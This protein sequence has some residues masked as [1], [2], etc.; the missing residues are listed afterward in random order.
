MLMLSSKLFDLP[1]LSLRAGNRISTA[2]K[3]II[4]PNNLKILGWW[5]L[6]RRE[7]HRTVLLTE[8]VREYSSRGL[9]VDDLDVLCDPSDLTRHKEILDIDFELLNKPVKTKHRK[10]GKVNDYNYNEGMFVQKLYVSRPVINLLSNDSTLIIDRSQILEVTDTHILV[11]DT[12]IEDKAT[13]LSAEAI[14]G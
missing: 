2:V 7:K 10:I 3:P 8:D 5:C 4:D 12:E 1:I 6:D 13:A 11:K 14:P 9:I